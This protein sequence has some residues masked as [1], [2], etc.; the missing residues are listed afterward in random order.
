VTWLEV[1]VQAKS[2]VEVN[3]PLVITS[4]LAVADPPG[5]TVAGDK[6]LVVREKAW[7]FAD[8]TAAAEKSSRANTKVTGR[9]SSL[10]FT[11]NDWELTTF[12]SSKPLNAAPVWNN[13]FPSPSPA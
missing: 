12:D 6:E 8:R 13:S 10:K 4:T 3:P 7:P 2:T 11:M 1:T 5:S 9:T